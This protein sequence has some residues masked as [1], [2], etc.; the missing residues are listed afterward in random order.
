MPAVRNN[1]NSGSANENAATTWTFTLSFTPT[2]GRCLLMYIQS[3]SA[4]SITSI[5]Q[6][7]SSATW[8]L[9]TSSV[10]SNNNIYVYALADTP[11]SSNTTITMVLGSANNLFTTIIEEVSGL[12]AVAANL[13]DKSSTFAGS[14][15]SYQTGT[16]ATT[17]TA[18]EYWVNIYSWDD[19]FLSGA[20]SGTLPTNGYTIVSPNPLQTSAGGWIAGG[21]SPAS[22]SAGQI[23]AYKIVTAT[24]TAGGNITDANFGGLAYNG[25]AIALNATAST[26]SSPARR[27]IVVPAVMM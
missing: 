7:G 26:S 12:V 5:T 3:R 20:P 15:D 10:V 17:T 14:G 24:G 9:I 13:L 22:I 11:V 2:S 18:D 25:L 6:G 1:L 23:V 19:Q 8:T 21:G 16:T 4:L 27:R